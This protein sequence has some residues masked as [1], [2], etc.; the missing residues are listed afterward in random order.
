MELNPAGY[1]RHWVSTLLYAAAILLFASPA[2]AKFMR[3]QDEPVDRLVENVSAYVKEHPDDV[4]GHYTLGR[5]HHLAFALKAEKLGIYQGK[6]EPL[7]NIPAMFNNQPAADSKVEEKVLLGHLKA[8]L[9]SYSTASTSAPDNALFQL[10]MASLM[11]SALDSGL[12]LPPL[13]GYNA[14]GDVKDWKPIYLSQAI[15]KYL[16]AYNM[17]IT[18]DLKVTHAPVRGMS[19]LISFEAGTQY[20]ALVQR[21][22][23]DKELKEKVGAVTGGL[24]ALSVKPQGP[25]TPIIFTMK[26]AAVL[27]DLLA[28]DKTVKFDL[29]GTQRGQDWAWVKPDTGILVWDPRATGVVTSAK[30]LFGSV[31]WWIFWRDG[32]SAMEALDDNHDGKL[33]GAELKGL[34]VW[35]DRNGNGVSDPGE[36]MPI[37]S[38]GVENIAVR[39]TGRDGISPTNAL[40]LRMKDGTVLAT[41]DW[42]VNPAKPEK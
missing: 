40:G 14:A 5:V 42:V 16:L 41:W 2:M 33:S 30:Q 39:A 34:A 29:D 28:P 32:Y 6:G 17:A 23:V 15:R 22:G 36:V 24:K 1:H 27:N 19:S 9:D 7:P 25:I 20:L 18:D 8:A 38:I 21:P 12:T 11:E 4:Q 3:P 26:H 31:T 37:E 35:F 10:G 13:P